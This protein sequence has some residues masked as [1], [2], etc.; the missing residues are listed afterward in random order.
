MRDS[1]IS[2]STVSRRTALAGLGAGGLGVA[3]AARTAAAQEANADL[4]G[5]LL[6]GSWAVMTPGG[7]VPQLHGADG[8]IV[9]FYPPNYVDPALGLTFQ[10]PALGRWEADGERSGHFTFLQA[11]SDASGAYT[12]TAQLAAGIEASA[13]GQTWSGT[14]TGPRVIVRDAANN[15]VFDE[16]IPLDPPVTAT[17]IGATAESVI[18][19]VAPPGAATPE[20]GTPT[21]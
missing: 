5:H 13:D 8:S 7:V 1:S 2:P 17:R 3:L 15:V 11:L 19:P 21:T 18:L 12:G 16:V 6:T 10:A 4:A 20:S 9:A 14:G